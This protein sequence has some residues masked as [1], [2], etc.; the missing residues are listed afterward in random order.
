VLMTIVFLLG[1]GIQI[2]NKF[3]A[4]AVIKIRGFIP[5]TDG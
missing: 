5:N 3:V 2:I 1:A 4:T